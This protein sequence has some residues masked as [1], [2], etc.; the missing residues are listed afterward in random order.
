MIVQQQMKQR[1]EEQQSTKILADDLKKKNQL[2]M[3]K[4]AEIESLKKNAKD[5]KE[6]I[7]QN[8][9]G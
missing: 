4:D 1:V 9:V 8:D 6:V 5:M 3:I 7:D 2:I